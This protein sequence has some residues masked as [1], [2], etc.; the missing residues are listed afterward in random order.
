MKN[1]VGNI[2]NWIKGA[3]ADTEHVLEKYTPVALHI[4]T[5]FAELLT[6]PIVDGVLTLTVGTTAEA[7]IEKVAADAVIGLTKTEA[8]IA[9]PTATE[10]LKALAIE[11]A[12]LETEYGKQAKIVKLAA[13][14]L[15]G[16]EG[17]NERQH[18][19]DLAAQAA[20]SVA[21]VAA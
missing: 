11:V 2:L 19:Y 3:E 6:N 1:L 14:I 21:L 5:I 17:G 20:Y 15:K 12:T 13:L 8:I 10:R 16:L 7:I 9:L 18:V 4:A